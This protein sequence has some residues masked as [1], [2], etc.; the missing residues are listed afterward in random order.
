MNSWSQIHLDVLQVDDKYFYANDNKDDRVHG[1]VGSTIPPVGFW[2]IIPS[3]EFRTGG[4][5]K[6]DLTSHVGPT[7]LSVSVESTCLE[8][9]RTSVVFVEYLIIISDICK[10]TL[11]WRRSCNQ[12]S[13]RRAMEKSYW[14]CISVS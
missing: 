12:I 3:D 14:P 4:P 5:H 11:C 13:T 7:V 6:Q 2:M 1:W 8:L 10:Y 9:R